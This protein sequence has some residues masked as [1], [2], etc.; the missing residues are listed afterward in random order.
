[1]LRTVLLGS[2]VLA[3]SPTVHAG[4]T[5]TIE[6]FDRGLYT[7]LLHDPGN[8]N[9]GTGNLGDFFRSFFVFDLSGVEG[10]IVAAEFRFAT[11][12]VVTPDPFETFQL[13]SIESSLEN[14]LS[15][16]A[17]SSGF[18]DLADGLVLGEL[19]LVAETK[20]L[21]YA[22]D[23]NSDALAIMNAQDGLW[24]FGG[25]ISTLDDDFTTNEGFTMTNAQAADPAAT[26]L[27]LTVIPAPG[28]LALLGAAGLCG[29]RRRRR[30]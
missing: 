18:A 6:A 28:V 25:H 24:G 4:T 19:D 1:M 14:I 8:T 29:R 12:I 20:D 3:S 9:Y 22:V 21:T 30:S 26:Q 23:L 16:A 15:G 13:V 5:I 10:E 27:I 17:G 2:A 11:G 7:S